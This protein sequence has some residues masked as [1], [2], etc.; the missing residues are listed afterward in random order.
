[1]IW[2]ALIGLFRPRTALQ[3]SRSLAASI[4]RFAFAISYLGFA[5][6]TRIITINDFKAKKGDKLKGAIEPK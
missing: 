5:V 1:L 3:S 2:Y 6:A 4:S